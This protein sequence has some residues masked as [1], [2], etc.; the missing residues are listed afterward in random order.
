MVISVTENQVSRLDSYPLPKPEDL[1]AQLARGKTFSILDLSQA[2][3]QIE[4]DEQSRKFAAINTHKGFFQ[5]TRLPYGVSSAPGIFQRTM[6]TLL[7]DIPAVMVYIAKILITEKSDKKHLETLERVLVRLEE[8]GLKL[9]RSKCLL[10]A[11]SVTYVGHKIDKDGI[12]PLAEKVRA[13]QKAPQPKSATELKA[14]LGLLS[15]YER[16]M[17]NL[18][19]M[20]APLYPIYCVPPH[21]GNGHPKS[22]LLLRLPRSFLQHHEC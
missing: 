11:P 13:V 22:K 4:L 12:H 10:M 17:P 21:L 8:S 14:Y 1:F 19:H 20:T 16:F 7:Q 18:A 9:K 2:Y 15:Y 3:L 6:E 5:F